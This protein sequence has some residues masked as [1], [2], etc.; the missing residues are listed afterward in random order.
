MR[1]VHFS[2]RTKHY[3][4]LSELILCIQNIFKIKMRYGK[5]SFRKLK[6]IFY[7]KRTVYQALIFLIN[8]KNRIL[9]APKNYPTKVFITHMPRK[10]YYVYD[11]RELIPLIKRIV[12]LLKY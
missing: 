10:Q 11:I 7:D 3:D 2:N 8:L 1:R 4:G 9:K 6:K 12:R 5:V